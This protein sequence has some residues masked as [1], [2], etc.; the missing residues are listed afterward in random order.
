MRISLSLLL[1]FSVSVLA[2]T[3]KDV[4]D[5]NSP[6]MN[7]L[8]TEGGLKKELANLKDQAAAH[9]GEYLFLKYRETSGGQPN[10]NEVLNELGRAQWEQGVL[11]TG[12]S[13]QPQ[14]LSFNVP[15]TIAGDKIATNPHTQYGVHGDSYKSKG[16]M[17]TGKVLNYKFNHNVQNLRIEGEGKAY[18]YD[19]KGQ[20]THEI[21]YVR[22]GDKYR[23]TCSPTPKRMDEKVWQLNRTLPTIKVFM[24]KGVCSSGCGENLRAMI[25]ENQEKL[26]KSGRGSLP[27]NKIERDPNEP[28]MVWQT[29]AKRDGCL[30]TD[31]LANFQIVS[32]RNGSKGNRPKCALDQ[33]VNLEDCSQKDCVFLQAKNGHVGCL[34]NALMTA[35]NKKNCL[36]AGQKP[37][38]LCQESI[39]SA[40]LP[41][42]GE[43][44]A[45]R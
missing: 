24:Q 5:P 33:G 30:P 12:F 6:L 43:G 20:I 14:T 2:Q 29:Q 32:V 35:F 40:R 9:I 15:G 11:L 8:F 37:P 4:C 3:Q 39:P 1:L 17:M 22:E 36:Q 45:D 44:T 13:C 41:V 31:L 18:K 34:S 28:C 38:R 19:D 16:Q 26:A 23:L 27:I 7:Q 25:K 10:C 21:V 42:V